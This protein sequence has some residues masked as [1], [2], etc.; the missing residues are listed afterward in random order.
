VERLETANGCGERL[1]GSFRSAGEIYFRLRSPV[2][3]ADGIE[4]GGYLALV[5]RT[6]ARGAGANREL[7]GVQIHTSTSVR[8]LA[9]RGK[10]IN[11]LFLR[12]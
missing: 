6:V 5:L 9:F 4:Q 7:N 3:G 10:S 11:M 12:R 2:T 8:G 1:N